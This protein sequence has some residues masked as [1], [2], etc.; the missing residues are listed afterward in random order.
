M[1]YLIRWYCSTSARDIGILY[2]IFAIYSAIIG[3]IYSYIIRIELVSSGNQY[4]HGNMQLYNVIITV[5]AFIMIFYFIM[6]GLIGAIGNYMVPLIIGVVDMSFARLNNISIWLLIPSIILVLVGA[7]LDNGVGAGWTLIPPLSANT[8]HYGISVDV[9][10]LG[11]HLAGIS[12][13]LGAIN[14][15]GTIINYRYSYRYMQ[16]FIWA[17]L[18][19]AILILLSIPVLA[20]AI[21]LLLLDRLYNTSF[22]DPIYGGDPILYMHLFWFFGHP[23]VYILILPGFG[24]ISHIICNYTNINIFGNIGMIYAIISIGILGFIVWSHHLYT[25]GLDTDTRAYFT[26]ATMIIAVPTGIK[27]FSWIATLYNSRIIYNTSLLFTYGFILLFTIGGITGIILANASVDIIL[28]DTY[29][30]VAHFH[31][32]LSM[33]ALFTLTS[34]I[35]YWGYILLGNIYNDLLGNIH[36]YTLFIG[37]NI[38][39]M[40]LHFIGLQ[41]MA[42]RIPDYP[43]AYIPYNY[44][45]T[46]GSSISIISTI[47]YIYIIYIL[48]NINNNII[49]IN[50]NISNINSICNTYTYSNTNSI[51]NTNYIS[52]TNNIYNNNIN[53]NII[54][55]I[56]IN[57]NIYNNHNI[58]NINNYNYNIHN[59]H[60]IDMI[61]YYHI[62]NY[63]NINNYNILLFDGYVIHNNI[64]YNNIISH[65]NIEWLDKSPYINHT[66]IESILIV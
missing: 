19:T 44:I 66:Y 8:G 28:H 4:M 59:I 18:I 32:V 9:T 60:N 39:F 30:V 65:I 10:I 16:L 2:L 13:I 64:L 17:I 27:V 35:Y 37:V 61:D 62:H 1:V 54:Y 5:H 58:N 46:I 41:G 14:Y 40:P 33:G 45:S 55:N 12:S 22:Y 25:I 11:L 42:R 3:S 29:Y 36:Y 23:E 6:P 51:N 57:Y 48:I 21:S 7:I 53:Y 15:I 52:N 63:Y 20:G 49:Y 43:D 24:I 26:G 56:N 47:L 38:T 50:H 34:G 31:Y